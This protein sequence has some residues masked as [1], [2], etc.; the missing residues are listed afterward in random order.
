MYA[1]HLKER[2]EEM[3]DA[4]ESEYDEK[5]SDKTLLIVDDILTTGATALNL[6]KSIKNKIKP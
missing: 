4:F 3:K 2:N 1:L 6:C 5:L